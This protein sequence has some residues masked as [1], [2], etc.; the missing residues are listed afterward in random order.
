MRQLPYWLWATAG[1]S[2]FLIFAAGALL[3]GNEWWLSGIVTVLIVA[4]L[5][6]VLAAIYA[7]SAWRAAILGAV[8]C[9]FLYIMLSLGPWFSSAVSPWLITTQALTTLDALVS[10]RESQLRQQQ[11]QVV[12]QTL[13]PTYYTGSTGTPWIG[14]GSTFIQP[15][16]IQGYVTTTVPTTASAGGPTTR[17]AM[18]HWLCGLV[19]AAC[20]WAAA[21]WVSR[22]HRA[23]DA[24]PAAPI[25]PGENPFGP[26]APPSPSAEVRP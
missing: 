21:G 19:A 18:G 1:G 6:G 14:G 7:D 10:D 11:Q 26:A 16:T 12:Y 8:I 22:R 20:G 15:Q 25:A 13:A 5:A 3:Y 23:R 24:A 9:G 2:A 4:W 17:V